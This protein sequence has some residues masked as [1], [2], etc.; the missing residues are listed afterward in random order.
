MS[1]LSIVVS[2][3]AFTEVLIAGRGIQTF[4]EKGRQSKSG[5]RVDHHTSLEYALS[6]R[7]LALGFECGRVFPAGV[8]SAHPRE[9][10]LTRFLRDS[11]GRLRRDGG[12]MAG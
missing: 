7:N 2:F 12:I 9:M 10:R 6:L 1:L 3:V 4:E 11:A 8:G 5:Q